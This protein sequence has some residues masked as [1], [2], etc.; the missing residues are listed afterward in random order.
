MKPT[1]EDGILS[2]VESQDVAYPII[3]NDQRVTLPAIHLTGIM[4]SDGKDPT[5][6]KDRPFHSRSRSLCHRRSAE[7]ARAAGEDEGSALSRWKIQNR[8]RENRVQGSAPGQPG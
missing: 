4:K 8:S 6:K 3:V 1:Y 5:P 2:R 7:S